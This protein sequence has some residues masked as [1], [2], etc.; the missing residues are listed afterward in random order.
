MI[1]CKEKHYIEVVPK[2]SQFWNNISI[3]KTVRRRTSP[4]ANV[5]KTAN[6]KAV[7]EPV[8]ILEL[9]Q[10]TLRIQ[11]YINGSSLKTG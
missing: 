5:C 4:K 1:L 6:K 8:D 9:P 2:L 7:P 3:F 11:A 10:R